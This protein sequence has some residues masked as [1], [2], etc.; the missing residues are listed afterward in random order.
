MI[1]G[2]GEKN[3]MTNGSGHES[4]NRNAIWHA[5][6]FL[7]RAVFSLVIKERWGV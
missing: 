3:R 2:N 4:D 1:A 5:F 6:A 7:D